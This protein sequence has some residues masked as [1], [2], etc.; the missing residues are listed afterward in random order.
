[1]SGRSVVDVHTLRSHWDELL[2]S[3]RVQSRMVC[4]LLMNCEPIT[5]DGD[6]VTLGF[7]HLFHLKQIEEPANKLLV[8]ETLSR[9]VGREVQLRCEVIDENG[10]WQERDS[11]QIGQ[12]RLWSAQDLSSKGE[13]DAFGAYSPMLTP[14]D[15]E[16]AVLAGVS[17]AFYDE[18]IRALKGSGSGPAAAKRLWTDP[19]PEWRAVRRAIAEYIVHDL[20]GLKDEPSQWK[21][22]W[23]DEATG[24]WANAD[25]LLYDDQRKQWEKYRERYG[26]KATVEDILSFLPFRQQRR[27]RLTGH[28]TDIEKLVERVL[29]NRGENYQFDAQVDYFLV[30]FLLPERKIIVECDGEHWHSSERQTGQDL[31]KSAHLESLGWEVYRLRFTADD[32]QYAVAKTWIDE[33]LDNG[34]RAQRYRGIRPLLEREAVV[35]QFAS[36]VAQQRDSVGELWRRTRTEEPLTYDRSQELLT[37]IREHTS[38][39]QDI[40]ESVA[41][42]YG[43]GATW[44]RQFHVLFRGE[45]QPRSLRTPRG[46][47]VQ[48]DYGSSSQN[49]YL[50]P[51]DGLQPFTQNLAGISEILVQKLR[52]YHRLHPPDH[53]EASYERLGSAYYSCVTAWLNPL[54]EMEFDRVGSGKIYLSFGPYIDQ[55]RKGQAALQESL[56]RFHQSTTRPSTSDRLKGL[57]TSTKRWLHG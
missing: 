52:T 21:K 10:R 17:R 24:K 53:L 27:K 32:V 8:T 16:K 9:I 45:P 54:C 38:S 3:I 34:E 1:M 35:D 48:I 31:K 55:M 23:L 28:R 4:A 51:P 40:L 47:W 19:S 30:D 37:F 18:Q 49:A 2:T 39:V 11:E 56:D 25:G 26:G 15:F 36:K 50:I 41:P 22:K 20:E 13:L 44:E 43:K 57:L 5:V 12:L 46:I 14:S 6:V 33:I 7:F 42:L 29:K